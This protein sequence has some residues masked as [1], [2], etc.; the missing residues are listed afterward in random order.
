MI[1]IIYSYCMRT[2]GEESKYEHRQRQIERKE[3]LKA[4]RGGTKGQDLHIWTDIC[5]C[6]HETLLRDHELTP[7]VGSIMG[8][9]VNR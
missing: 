5:N 2:S 1:H 3:G 8:Q 9:E 4:R 7:R 6:V